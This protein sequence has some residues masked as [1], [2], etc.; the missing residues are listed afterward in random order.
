MKNRKVAGEHLDADESPA[1]SDSSATFDARKRDRPMLCMRRRAPKRSYTDEREASRGA[2]TQVAET[3]FCFW[4]VAKFVTS[5]VTN[6]ATDINNARRLTRYLLFP[7]NSR[8]LRN[9]KV[10]PSI[11]V[12]WPVNSRLSH[13]QRE[14]GTFGRGH[15][16]KL[17]GVV[18]LDLLQH[19]LECI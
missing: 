8:V 15:P 1:Q 6:A 3:D 19:D 16:M 14:A 2:R 12:G 13:E 9:A 7:C 10:I 18:S 11:K 4:T 17:R 5:A